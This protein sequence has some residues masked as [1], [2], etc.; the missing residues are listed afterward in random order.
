[1]CNKSEIGVEIL[2]FYEKENYLD[3]NKKETLIFI[4]LNKNELI[5]KYLFDL[6]S[7]WNLQVPTRFGL[8]GKIHNFWYLK[9]YYNL[10][11]SMVS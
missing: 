1:L 10:I 5:K 4:I 8:F 9:L 7:S 3:E 2:K 11:K 6:L